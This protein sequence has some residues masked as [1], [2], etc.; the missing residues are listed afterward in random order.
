MNNRNK[1][2]SVETVLQMDGIM[3][4]G[5]GV[6]AKFP[7]RD[8]ALKIKDKAIY[9][10][11]CALSGSGTRAWPSRGKILSDLQIGKAAF[12]NSME[13]LMK[14]G[15]LTKTNRRIHGEKGFWTKT[16]YTI[17]LNPKR[18]QERQSDKEPDQGEPETER[19]TLAMQGMMYEGWGFAPRLV[20]QDPRLSIREK[21]L[22]I[23]ILT[24]AAAGRV[25]YPDV[26]TI[27]YHLGISEESYR[28]L[29]NQL[30]YLGYIVRWRQRKG[31]GRLG[32]YDYFICPKP[33]TL[34]DGAEVP[35]GPD[36]GVPPT[37][38]PDT[39]KPDTAVPQP[40][41]LKPDTA[42]QEPPTSK[43]DTVKPD[44]VAPDVTPREPTP[45]KRDTVEPPPVKRDT[46]TPDRVAQEPPTLKPDTVKPDTVKTDEIT[47][48]PTSKPDT[49]QPDTVEPDTADK[50]IRLLQESSITSFTI[51]T[52]QE[53]QP[54]TTNQPEVGMEDG[55]ATHW[56]EQIF[57]AGGIPEKMFRHP[58]QIKEALCYLC[59]MDWTKGERRYLDPEKQTAFEIV[60][61]AMLRLCTQRR[62]KI[63]GVVVTQ[64]QIVEKFNGCCRKDRYGVCMEDFIEFAVCD[65]VDAMQHR[66][67]AGLAPVRSPIPYAF[68]V[69]WSA[70]DRF[71]QVTWEA[72]QEASLRDSLAGNLNMTKEAHI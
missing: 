8:T 72:A 30:C 17:E 66:R 71:L 25:A 21:A 58:D 48:P 27:T 52:P 42:A 53:Y 19:S 13:R 35:G 10:Y 12:Y 70:A 45:G 18:Y 33:K 37:S 40:S 15:Y 9:A 54:T 44:T 5:Y 29:I 28:K 69:L 1:E 61:N 11:L 64:K 26:P 23:Y 6:V 47:L 62:S 63:S 57:R 4:K 56:R 67:E 49:V 3:A 34:Y 14:E 32:R 59:D 24:Y 43:P 36:G 60:M 55:R 2:Y 46:V 51:T 39:V 50:D 41:P 16:I 38:E 20:M 65:Y 68:S 31:N 7:M 22:Y